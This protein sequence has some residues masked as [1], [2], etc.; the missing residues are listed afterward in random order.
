[1]VPTSPALSSHVLCVSNSISVE[2]LVH[3]NSD[4]TVVFLPLFMH[5]IT[6][7][8][9]IVKNRALNDPIKHIKVIVSRQL[10]KRGAT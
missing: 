4:S 10:P 6:M 3:D 9:L 2:Q 5:T 8:R 1:M 7:P